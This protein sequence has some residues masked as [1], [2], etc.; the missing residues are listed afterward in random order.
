MFSRMKEID[1]QAAS[2]SFAGEYTKTR[3][4]GGALVENNLLLNCA[5]HGFYMGA[6]FLEARKK[7]WWS[8][9]SMTEVMSTREASKA[10]EFY[11]RHRLQG[12]NPDQDAIARIAVTK[13][14]TQGIKFREETLTS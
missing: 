12:L 3:M 8:R 5:A 11:I 10:A 4:R 1:L 14:F 13:G 9:E 7:R 6:R 2:A